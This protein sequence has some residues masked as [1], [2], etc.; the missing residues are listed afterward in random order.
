M[1][2][3]GNFEYGFSSRP[4]LEWTNGSLK[5]FVHDYFNGAIEVGYEKVKFEKSFNARNLNRIDGIEIIWTDNLADHLK[6]IGD[7]TQVAIFHYASFLKH[8]S[9]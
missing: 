9:R 7:D 1:I 2:T 3:I 4:D 6:M 8:Q 5:D